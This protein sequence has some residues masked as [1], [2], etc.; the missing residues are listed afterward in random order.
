M[1]FRLLRCLVLSAAVACAATGAACAATVSTEPSSALAVRHPGTRRQPLDAA[2][3]QRLDALVAKSRALRLADDPQWRAMLHYH[4]RFGFLAPRALPDSANF[5]MSSHG[6]TDAAAELEATLAGFFSDETETDRTQNPQCRFRARFAWLDARLDFTAAGLAR[7]PCARFDAWR[8]ALDPGRVTLVFASAYLNSP[9][10][11]Y[12]HTLLRIDPPDRGAGAGLL[13]YAVNFAARTDGSNALLYALRGLAGGYVG[14][15]ATMPYYTKVAEYNDIENRD[16]WE[17]ELTLTAPEIDRMLAHLWE[18]GPV[19]YDYFFLDENC[20]YHLLAVLEVARPG[21]RLTDRFPL[22]AIPADTVRAVARTDGLVR[23]V[24]YRPARGTVLRH[25]VRHAPASVVDAADGLSAGRIAPADLKT[26]LPAEADRAQAL[27]MGY[28]LLDYRRLRGEITGPAVPS[29]VRELLAAR[30]K[31]DG[32]PAPEP[33]RPAVRPDEGHG[34]LRLSLGGGTQAGDG[35]QE[36]RL[37]MAYHDLMDPE[38]GF[39][40]GGQLDF[41]GLALRRTNDDGRVAFDRFALAEVMSLT[42]RESLF[43][44]WSWRGGVGLARTTVGPDGHRLPVAYAN[45]GGGLSVEPAP[46]WLAYGLVEG[47]VRASGHLDG[48][49]AIGPAVRAGVYV[50]ASP[51]W[52]LH[53]YAVVG[54]RIAGDTGGFHDVGFET[55][56]TL[57]PGAAVTFEARRRLDF[58]FRESRVAAFA[59]LYF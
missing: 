13:S 42:P 43:R 23:Q 28:E 50:D 2:D 16:V 10:S 49:Y 52:R 29:R 38:P 11:A 1:S 26:R 51:T 45:M 41:L 35:F 4:P 46:G 30:A 58:G 53:P 7:R 40:R 8:Q 47:D 34:S 18:L 24:G 22:Y 6:K 31:V 33:P 17:Y 15:F 27:E 54:R 12:G 25:W 9:S 48:G 3:A 19:E 57:A 56:V 36:V 37:R 21:L 5:F 20:A 32:P 14:A 55:R 59:H 39:L 44:S